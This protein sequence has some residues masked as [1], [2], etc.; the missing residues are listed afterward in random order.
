MALKVLTDEEA[1]LAE[2]EIEKL[3]QRDTF[4]RFLP[5]RF[6]NP[7]DHSFING[8]NTHGRIWECRPLTFYGGKALEG[9]A[10]LLRQ[11]F[12]KGFVMQVIQWPDRK[13]DSLLEQ[14]VSL[15]TRNDPLSNEAAKRYSEF[16]SAGRNGLDAVG[17]TPVRIFRM[18]VAV[19]SLDG[20]TNDRIAAIEE[21]LGQSG[22]APRPVDAGGLLSFLRRLFN[23]HPS[24][25]D[26]AWDEHRYLSQQIINADSPVVVEREH[27]RLGGKWAACLTPKSLPT[28]EYL[29]T[30]QMNRITGGFGGR[31]DDG[32]QMGHEYLWTTTIFMNVE[33]ANIRRKASLLAM[34]KVGGTIAK[35]IARR[36]Q[37][38]GWVLDDLEKEKRYVNV[39]TAM[40]VFGTSAEDLDKGVARARRLWE[41]QQF[42]MQRETRLCVPMLIISLPFGLY[43]QGSNVTTIDRDFQVSASAAA[44]LLPLQGDF[45]GYMRPVLL[46]LGRKGQ[47]ASIDV[48][49]ERASNQNFFVAAG[50]GGGK[51]FLMNNLVQNYYATGA[52][53]RIVDI[54][55]SYEKQCASYKGTFIDV[56]E[57]RDK[58]CL[59]PFSSLAKDKEDQ[60]KDELSTATMLL[61]MIFSSTG[62]DGVTETHW[63]L[64]K[65]AVR[66]AKR[67]DGGLLGV[68]HAEEFLRR[69]AELAAPGARLESAIPIAN[70]MGFNLRDFTM[71]GKYGRL[72]NGKSTLN[73][74]KDD[75]V[76][77]ELENIMSDR[78]LFQVISMQ[79]I[80]AITQDLYLSDRRD[81]R[82]MLFDEAW[83]YFTA[84][85]TIAAMIVEMYRRARKYGG[86]TG[87]VTQSV[88]DLKGFGNA[89][90]VVKNNSAFKFFLE[91]DSFPAAVRDGLLDYEGLLL[92]L[93]NSVKNNKPRYSEI[94][95]DTPFGCGVGRL[96]VDR[97]TYWMNTSTAHEVAKFKS[98]IA[99]GL[100]EPEALAR[101][102]A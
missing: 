47:L 86:A 67:Q 46:Y 95:F 37:E 32:F 1:G 14:Y 24:S 92:E 83:K 74:A 82:F 8:D 22:L 29:D 2:G 23:Q 76:V 12:P 81:R 19:K 94:L 36:N 20:F 57:Q 56:G 80:N 99:Q 58:L 7:K 44:H 10:G 45:S 52:K 88:L 18:F 97:W 17:G 85:P 25:N 70:E 91:S 50:T 69:Y 34:Q 66:Y 75:F 72:F 65:D 101:L 42:V 102:A 90:V 38:F 48:F 59:N 26:T 30:L 35:D 41:G 60:A 33:P 62:L 71:D 43:T 55:Y 21:A 61:T 11:E 63:S 3:A 89:G 98:L 51:S 49:D 28:G 93:A 77:L 64:A 96:C 68:T 15:K 13:I 100:T 27:L 73:I 79:A 39:I 87:I 4:S 53:V 84:A 31:D 5:Y 6:F 9:M 40:W 78:E 54:G 16:L